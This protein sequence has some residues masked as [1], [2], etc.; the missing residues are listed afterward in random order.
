MVHY[1]M[2]NKNTNI[3]TNTCKYLCYVIKNVK[4]I[5]TKCKFQCYVIKNLWRF[6][7]NTQII[8]TWHDKALN[9]TSE[10]KSWALDWLM[11]GLVD[12]W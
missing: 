3:R 11:K 8:Q 1:K 7:N 12:G 6:W 10:Y 9:E 2:V 4:S 5:N